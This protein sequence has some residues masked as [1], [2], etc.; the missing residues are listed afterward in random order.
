MSAKYFCCTRGR[1]ILELIPGAFFCNACL[2]ARLPEEKSPDSRYCQG[3][4][5]V[6]TTEA[7][8]I[9]EAG[10][11]SRPAWMPKAITAVS[12]RL[13]MGDKASPLLGV[14][15]T[16]RADVSRDNNYLQGNEMSTSNKRGRYKVTPE[17]A[18]KIMAL[19]GQG[20]G[21]KAIATALDNAVTYRT[22][23]RIVKEVKG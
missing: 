1:M 14:G 13:P 20:F 2:V 17:L 16:I 19:S 22:V 4:H 21:S 6:L 7:Q 8:A 9:K 15:V 11:K 18:D 23:L 10:S 5:D 12:G 3:C